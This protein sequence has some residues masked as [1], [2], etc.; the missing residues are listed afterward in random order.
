MQKSLLSIIIIACFFTSV[1]QERSIPKIGDVPLYSQ[2]SLNNWDYEI[3][4]QDTLIMQEMAFDNVDGNTDAT[5]ITNLGL[6]FS[7]DQCWLALHN[8][9]EPNS[10]AGSNSVFDPAGQADRWMIT[11]AIVVSEDAKLKW[12][13][14]S[15][16]LDILPTVETYEVYISTSGG[17]DHDAFTE[18]PIYTESA[19]PDSWDTKI[20]DLTGYAEDTVY[21]AFRHTSND[22]G[23]LAIDDIR[24]GESAQTPDGMGGNFENAENFSFDMTPWTTIDVDQSPTYVF[25]NVTFPNQ[26]LNMS[27]IVFNPDETTPS[28]SNLEANGGERL[29]ACFGAIMPTQ[30]GQGPNDDWLISPKLL[31]ADNSYIEFYAKSITSIYDL[32]RFEV[33]VS[34]TDLDPASFTDIISPAPYV[35]VGTDWTYFHY[36]LSTYEDQEIYVGIHCISENAFVFC[37]DDI[38]IHDVTGFSETF[39]DEIEI[40]P[41][42]TRDRIILSGAAGFDVSIFNHLGIELLRENINK[43]NELNLNLSDYPGGIY[44]IR[45]EKDGIH[46]IQKVIKL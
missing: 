35:N 2:R 13:A 4:F 6:N 45:M 37:I 27:F 15:I 12:R 3:D 18:L 33:A 43:E 39:E 9:G 32:E 29:G 20:I 8:S 7:G 10:W 24:V 16:Q 38:Y 5:D 21:I 30:G 40:Y 19:T 31:M 25:S 22:Q 23:I 46:T 26:G 41:N 44:Y 36:D 1:G 14:M 17:V 11:P 42:P 34:T 28:L